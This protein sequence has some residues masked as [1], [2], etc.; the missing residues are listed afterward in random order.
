MAPF[1]HEGSLLF[2]R[3]LIQ[4][5]GNF[6]SIRSPAKCAA[7]IGQA[8][9]DTRT[10]VPIDPRLALYQLRDVKNNNRVF[11]DGVGTMSQSLMEKIW[12]RLPKKT[13][14]RPTCLQIRFQGKCLTLRG[15]F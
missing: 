10:A 2:D 8:F 4:S 15:T 1:L 3:M 13:L 11:S 5:L 14:P 6:A 9:S 12:E 7:R